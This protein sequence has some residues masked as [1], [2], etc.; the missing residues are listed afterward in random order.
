MLIPG[1]QLIQA[2]AAGNAVVMKPGRDGG[3]PLA[4][5][6]RLAKESG[7]DPVLTPLLAVSPEAGQAALAAGVDKVFLTKVFLTGSSET[8]AD[9]LGAPGAT[10]G[11][12]GHGA[13]RQ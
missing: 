11:G 10:A 12:C 6:L 3:A 5:L 7:I 4:A 13:V 2:L 1:V 9:V 8:G